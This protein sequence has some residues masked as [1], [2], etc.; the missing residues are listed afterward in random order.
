MSLKSF[1]HCVVSHF[2]RAVRRLLAVPSRL[3]FRARLE[4]TPFSLPVGRPVLNYGSVLPQGGIVQGG[5][6]KLLHLTGPFPENA[7]HFNLLYLVSSAIPPH[8]VE[9]ACWAKARG[10][11]LVWN[12]NG[13]GFPA[14]A[15]TGTEEINRP[16]R[17]LLRM[18][19]YVF[20]QS[21]F[22]QA[23]ATRFLGEAQCESSLVFNPVDTA[24]FIPAQNPPPATPVRLLTAGTHHQPYRV[25][26][27]IECLRILREKVDARLVIA[28][29]LRWRGAE[30]QIK[31]MIAGLEDAVTLHSA[32]TQKEAVGLFQS[33]HFLLHPK[34]NDPCPT[35][36]LEAMACGLPVIGSASGGMPELVG[37]EGGRLL[38]PPEQTWET[39]HPPDPAQ[40]AEA[41]I[42]LM[43]PIYS[44]A[45]RARAER[46]FNKE[47]WV[48]RHRAVFERLTSQ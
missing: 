42:A 39:L 4:R 29:G 30:A 20:Y 2:T 5:K 35:V 46:L 7:N 41:V 33:A 26:S 15:G 12:Q 25:T 38:M 17:E 16:M 21:A 1:F 11:K 48:D 24:L 3:A 9:L 10:V 23:S 45:A 6:V 44:R 28:G 34:F 31:A 32:Y 14:W 19:D 18:A 40:M 27:A 13:V 43:H 47:L 37:E 8:G 22:C 36:V